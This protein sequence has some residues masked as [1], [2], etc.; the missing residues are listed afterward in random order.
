M[1]NENTVNSGQL[2]GFT[3]DLPLTEG[4]L[5]EQWSLVPKHLAVC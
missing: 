4:F 1:F 3:H 2:Q 5:A